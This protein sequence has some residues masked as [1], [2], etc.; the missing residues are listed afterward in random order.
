MFISLCVCMGASSQQFMSVSAPAAV[1]AA[2]AVG[3][4]QPVNYVI[5]QRV[6]QGWFESQTSSLTVAS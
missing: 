2:A 5:K 6:D 4:E 3:I 1:S